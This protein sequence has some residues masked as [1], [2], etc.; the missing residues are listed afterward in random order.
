[1]ERWELA[2]WE[3]VVRAATIMNRLVGFLAF[4]DGLGRAGHFCNAGDRYQSVI[5]DR[6]RHEE[7]RYQSVILDR[8][9]HEEHRYQS[10][11]LDRDNQEVHRYQ[12]VVFEQDQGWEDRYHSV[13]LEDVGFMELNPRND[14]DVIYAPN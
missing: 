7:H 6:D 9:R 14:S 13:I 11:I 1:M 12:S 5:L 10:V 8:D 3:Y 2:K 4:A